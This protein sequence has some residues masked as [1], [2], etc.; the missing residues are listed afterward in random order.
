MPHAH[1]SP[2]PARSPATDDSPLI[3]NRLVGGRRLVAVAEPTVWD[4]DGV[5]LAAAALVDLVDRLAPLLAAGRVP[6]EAALSSALIETNGWLV[7][8]LRGWTGFV[9]GGRVGVGVSVAVMAPEVTVFALV[10]PAQAIA[11]QSGRRVD[12]PSLGSWLGAVESV[13]GAPLGLGPDVVPTLARTRARSDDVVMVM[14]SATARGLAELERRGELP[15]TPDGV[16]AAI[17]ERYADGVTAVEG[18]AHDHCL[19][20]VACAAPSGRFERSWRHVSQAAADLAWPTWIAN[21]RPRPSAEQVAWSLALP[22]DR[23]VAQ[24]P[25]WREAARAASCTAP[26]PRAAS[27]VSRMS[28]AA[29]WTSVLVVLVVLLGGVGWAIDASSA[30][31]RPESPHVAT[32]REAVA[33]AEASSRP[34]DIDRHLSDAE[35]ALVRAEEDGADPADLDPLYGQVQTLRDRLD[36]HGRLGP[37]DELGRLPGNE[38]WSRARLALHG[39]ELF[40]LDGALYRFDLAG[41]TLIQELAAGDVVD[42]VTAR[43]FRDLASDQ[44]TLVVNDGASVF[45]RGADGV[46]HATALSQPLADGDGEGELFDGNYYWLDPAD[47]Q[48]LRF[49]SDD[50]GDRPRHW[51][52]DG[53]EVDLSLAVDI[54]VDGHVFL[55]QPNGQILDL[56][57]GHV[58]SDERLTLDGADSRGRA[59]AIPPAGKAM[60]VVLDAVSG[61]AVLRVDRVTGDRMAYL[62]MARGAVGYDPTDG[63]ALRGAVE[64]VVDEPSGTLYLI[65]DG[66][67]WSTTI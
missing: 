55:L 60:Y 17:E 63:D 38:D 24:A 11:W 4:E 44:T 52:E 30:K 43:P 39:R 34:G 27:P 48:V 3:V 22:M 21:P 67:I 25:S 59:L 58:V 29:W 54:A 53:N 42:G 23:Y 1:A 31:G 12:L 5:D 35:I 57:K 28:R 14:T 33:D 32:A 8:Q 7:E 50:Y 41:R 66:A 40:V 62:P 26:R 16:L 64:L 65:A 18:P 37:I 61:A 51:I 56:Y 9:P 19:V 49:G 10:A 46:W 2:A 13:G 45:W 20:A 47:D 15:Q 36:H 6:I